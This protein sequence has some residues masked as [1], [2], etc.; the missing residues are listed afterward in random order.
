MLNSITFN[1]AAEF[2]CTASEFT[3]SHNTLD[4]PSAIELKSDPVLA[5]V[6][7]FE[8]ETKECK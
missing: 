6:G 7:E 2:K 3:K 4:P 8:T 1:A 5:Y